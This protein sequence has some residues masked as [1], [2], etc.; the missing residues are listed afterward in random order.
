VKE[1]KVEIIY[2]NFKLST[3]IVTQFDLLEL[4]PRA[5]L[6]RSV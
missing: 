4:P 6:T 1:C 5:I 3:P 2:S